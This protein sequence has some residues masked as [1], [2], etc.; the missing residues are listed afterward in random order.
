[1]FF[2]WSVP[3]ERGIPL[4]EGETRTIETFLSPSDPTDPKAIEALAKGFEVRTETWDQLD[5]ELERSGD[6]S[7]EV[8]P[9]F[10]RGLVRVEDAASF[11]F[12]IGGMFGGSG[13]IVFRRDGKELYRRR[14]DEQWPPRLDTETA[15]PDA[16]K[17]QLQAGRAFEWGFEDAE[18][19]SHYVT[20]RVEAIDVG[21]EIGKL[22]A[23]MEGRAP[24]VEHQLVAQLYLNRGLDQAAYQEAAKVLG[25]A[26]RAL[27]AISIMTTA[28]TNLGLVDSPLWNELVSRLDGTSGD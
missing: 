3:W 27:K 1:M 25:D 5:L 8:V 9:L 11:R 21:P 20:F 19:T 10:P 2:G 23:R 7:A 26:P 22:R 28:L 17:E 12:R 14:F 15:M 6:F 18:G 4:E 16:V 13:S 24:L